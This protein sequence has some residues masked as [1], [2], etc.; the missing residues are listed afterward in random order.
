MWLKE[1][2]QS[3]LQMTDT[4]GGQQG[5]GYLFFAQTKGD[6]AYPVHRMVLETTNP[7][8]ELSGATMIPQMGCGS[9]SDTWWG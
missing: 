3:G 6:L 8:S 4:L 2:M 7:G 9:G 1:R 5:A